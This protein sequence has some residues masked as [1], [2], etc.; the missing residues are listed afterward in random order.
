MYQQTF[1][2]TTPGCIMFLVDRSDSMKQPWAELRPHAR[3]GS[4][5]GDQQ[6]AARA[7]RQVDQGAR[8]R[9]CAATSTSASYGYGFCP[10]SGGEGV[11]S[12]L[13]GAARRPRHRPAARTGRPADR[14]TRGAVG[15]R[16]GRAGRGC[17]CGSSRTTASARRCARRSPPRASTSTSW[18]NAFP[19]SFPPIVINITDGMVTDSPYDG[20]DLATWAQ[21]LTTIATRDGPTL[22]LNIFLSPT[23]APASGS[24]PARRACREPG[25]GLFAISSELPRPM[26]DNARAAQVQVGPGRPRSRLQRRPRDAGEV[27]GDRHPRSTVGD[28][29]ICDAVR[30]DGGVPRGRRSAR[31]THEWE[32]GAGYDAGD[33]AAGRDARCI[34]VDGATEAYDSIRWVGQLVESFVGVD[35]AGGTPA[36]SPDGDGRVVRR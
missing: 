32:D 3:R 13:P 14:R 30:G 9:A 21:R 25:P 29:L 8:R 34:V 35:P 36:L 28:R 7:V 4:G 2:R 12:A 6:D 16:D 1:S 19:N 26:I 5:P 18:A 22:L 11:E 15:G 31:P 20:A 24:R 33:P 23:K 17:R 27:P 10:S